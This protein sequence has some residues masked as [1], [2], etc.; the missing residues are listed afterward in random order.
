MNI[1]LLFL[2]IEAGIGLTVFILIF[3]FLYQNL[4]RSEK[5]DNQFDY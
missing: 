3:L 2:L 5:D 1:I 4:K